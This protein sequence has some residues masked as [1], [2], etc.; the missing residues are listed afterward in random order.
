MNTNA[1]KTILNINKNLKSYENNTNYKIQDIVKALYIQ[2]KI[3]NNIIDEKVINYILNQ[4]QQENVIYKLTFTDFTPKRFK[5]RGGV[6]NLIGVKNLIQLK[7]NITQIKISY[8]NDNLII[9]LEC[10]KQN[11]KDKK[12]IKWFKTFKKLKFGEDF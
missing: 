1:Y 11:I 3:Y 4:L 2:N 12:Y 7:N 9:I 10:Y 8:K 6:L 5:Y